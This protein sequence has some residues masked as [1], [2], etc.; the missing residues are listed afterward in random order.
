MEPVQQE[1]HAQQTVLRSV[2]HVLP[3]ITYPVIY[4]F[5]INANVPMEPV[6]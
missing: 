4:A 1:Q 2:L 5:R 3:D 6:Q